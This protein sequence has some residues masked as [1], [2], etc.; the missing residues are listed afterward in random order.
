MI[1]QDILNAV[2]KANPEQIMKLPCEYNL[3]LGLLS[4]PENCALQARDVKVIFS[5]SVFFPCALNQKNHLQ[6]LEN[7]H[8]PHK[9]L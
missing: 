3:Q 4:E 6:S 2:F 5:F 1:I 8:K 7:H 9:K